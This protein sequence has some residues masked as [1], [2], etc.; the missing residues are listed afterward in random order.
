MTEGNVQAAPPESGG[1]GV[2]IHND[3]DGSTAAE[4]NLVA[5][6]IALVVLIA[7]LA[8]MFYALPNWL[9]TGSVNTSIRAP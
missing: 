1:E 4:I 5:V 8:L 3:A 6:V 9:G 2:S 7:F